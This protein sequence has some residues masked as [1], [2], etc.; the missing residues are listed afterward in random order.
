MR[1]NNQSKLRANVLVLEMLIFVTL[2]C[3]SKARAG[4]AP[5]AKCERQGFYLIYIFFFY[6]FDEEKLTMLNFY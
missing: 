5:K 3:L 2:T 1:H 4:Q 6:K